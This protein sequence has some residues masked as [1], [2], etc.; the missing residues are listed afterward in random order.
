MK[1]FTFTPPALTIEA[2]SALLHAEKSVSTLGFR[3]LLIE[4]GAISVGAADVAAQSLSLSKEPPILGWG[5]AGTVREVGS[6]VS[7]FQP[8]DEVYYMHAGSLASPGGYQRFHRVD[9]RTVGHRPRSLSATEAAALPFAALIAWELLFDRLGVEQDSGDGDCL[10]I[11]GDAAGA[12][13]MLVQLAQQLTRLTVIASA[14]SPDQAARLRQW[15]AHHVIDCT[16]PLMEQLQAVAIADVSH[17]VSLARTDQHFLQ[18]I[19]VLRPQGRIGVIDDPRNL[20]ALLLKSKSLSLHWEMIFTRPL[21][22]TA[23][24]I[25]QHYLL[26]RVSTLFDQGLLQTCPEADVSG[27]AGDDMDRAQALIE[28]FKGSFS[29]LK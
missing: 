4:I 13:S 21:Y 22:A 20:D 9:E 19:E 16:Q 10:L 8:G 1:V 28:R 3:G 11:I 24:M 7:L 2:A 14:T 6:G 27:T 5:A 17:V 25:N 15:G 23:D 18:L 12:A 29:F 26:N